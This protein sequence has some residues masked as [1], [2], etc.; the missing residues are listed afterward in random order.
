MAPK[1]VLVAVVD[2]SGGHVENHTIISCSNVS[3]CS[4]W[5]T[6]V[7]RWQSMSLHYAA[8]NYCFTTN[9]H[10]SNKVTIN[11][12]DTHIIIVIN[13]I[14]Q[15]LRKI[16]IQNICNVNPPSGFGF[17]FRG[18][19]ALW[20][21]CWIPESISSTNCWWRV[22]GRGDNFGKFWIRSALNRAEASRS[23]IAVIS[24]IIQLYK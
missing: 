14:L 23:T 15:L 4:K 9:N 8:I 3:C 21:T 17:I 6:F 18:E 19:S 10:L 22:I 20:R 11:V 5:L 1:E 2:D 16:D 24:W 13:I 7:C 12:A